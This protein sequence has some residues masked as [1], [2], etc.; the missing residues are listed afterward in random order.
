MVAAVEQLHAMMIIE[1]KA[2]RAVKLCVVPCCCIVKLLQVVLC[3]HG[4]LIY[5]VVLRGLGKGLM[6]MCCAAPSR[7]LT[8]GLMYD[9]WGLTD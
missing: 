4:R 6:C 3:M 7:S 2:R 8:K 9:D 1:P 5:C